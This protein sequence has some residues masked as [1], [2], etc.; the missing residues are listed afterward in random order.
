MKNRKII[1]KKA[2]VP[3]TILVIGIFALCTFALITFF[4]SQFKFNNS[5]LV[6]DDIRAM[7]IY[8]DQWEHYENLNLSNDQILS[9]IDFS[10]L[11]NEGYSFEISFNENLKTIKISKIKPESFFNKLKDFFS[12]KIEE[13]NV[14]YVLEYSFN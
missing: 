14:Q 1:S 4:V 6:V 11:E 13:K 3:I 2:S 10:V 7:N 12:E 9:K 8:V 5:F